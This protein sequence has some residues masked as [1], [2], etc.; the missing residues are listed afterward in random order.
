[1]L[2]LRAEQSSRLPAAQLLLIKDACPQVE[3]VEVAKAG[4][5]LILDQPT[6]TVTLVQEFL[7][8]HRLTT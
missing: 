4:H 5:H 3:F 6:Q 7:R 2:F 1:V 8:R